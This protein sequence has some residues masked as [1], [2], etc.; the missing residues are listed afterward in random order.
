MG[1]VKV[2]LAIRLHLLSDSRLQKWLI[3]THHSLAH[4]YREANDNVGGHTQNIDHIYSIQNQI[5]F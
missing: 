2:S 1:S 5:V 4:Q 3:I